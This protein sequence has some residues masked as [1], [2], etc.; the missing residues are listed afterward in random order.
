MVIEVAGDQGNIDVPALADGFAVVHGFQHGEA[1][2]VLLHRPRQRVQV[3][4]SRVRGERLP[5]RQRGA[6]GAD[7]GVNVRCGSLGDGG[8]LLAGRG[9][10]GFE[11]STF[12]RL[13]PGAVN[14]MSEAAAMSIQP[15]E[16]LFRVLRRGTVFHGNELFSDAHNWFGVHRTRTRTQ[17]KSKAS[18]RSVRPTRLLPYASGWR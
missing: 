7:G 16:G 17:S 3:A 2:G 14:K 9:I 8:E 15:G 5:L 1:A 12:R 4:C 6:G 11:V 13:S 18:D 10:S